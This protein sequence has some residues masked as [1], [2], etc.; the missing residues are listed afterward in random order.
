MVCQKYRKFST[1]IYLSEAMKV[2]FDFRKHGVVYINGASFS[3]ELFIEIT[4]IPDLTYVE[5]K[6]NVFLLRAKTGELSGFFKTD[7]L[8]KWVNTYQFYIEVFTNAVLDARRW[9]NDLTPDK[10]IEIDI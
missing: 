1:E 4:G 9:Y 7:Q 8:S 5:P 2:K 3:I 10:T 6:E